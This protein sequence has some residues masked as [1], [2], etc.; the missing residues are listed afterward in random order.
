MRK[1]V[2]LFLSLFGLVGL[3]H[4]AGN[5]DGVSGFDG[6][7]SVNDGPLALAFTSVAADGAYTV[8][9][10]NVVGIFTEN[11][12]IAAAVEVKSPYDDQPNW[13]LKALPPGSMLYAMGLGGEW[14]ALDANINNLD[15]SKAKAKGEIKGS[16]AVLT[17]VRPAG[18]TCRVVNWVIVLPDGKRTWGPNGDNNETGQHSPNFVKVGGKPATAWCFNGPQVVAMD[19]DRK[20]GLASK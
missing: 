11:P 9:A 7:S 4:A 6:K 13:I 8:T 1:L 16:T 3:A 19:A 10:N 17:F 15:L 20:T 12:S 2:L 18:Q 5:L 14:G